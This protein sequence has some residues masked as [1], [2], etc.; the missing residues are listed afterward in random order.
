MAAGSCPF[1]ALLALVAF[2]SAGWNACSLASTKFASL[3]RRIFA[4]AA[5]NTAVAT[6]DVY[7]NFISRVLYQLPISSHTMACTFIVSDRQ[8]D[9]WF[10][11]LCLY[12][13][14]VDA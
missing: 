12:S 2:C 10:L 4:I 11:S 6:A 5:A 7:P 14:P 9:H 8:C 1:V 13:P 3:A